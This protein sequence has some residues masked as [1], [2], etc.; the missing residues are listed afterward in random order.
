MG[1]SANTFYKNAPIYVAGGATV[2]DGTISLDSVKPLF[3]KSGIN[4]TVLQNLLNMIDS[5]DVWVD[6]TG[7]SIASGENQNTYLSAKNFGHY[8]Q[9]LLIL[10]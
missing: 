5:D 8:V 2:N 9:H 6:E 10:I 1:L 4:N 7:E 3:S